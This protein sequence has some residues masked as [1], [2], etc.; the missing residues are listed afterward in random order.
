MLS[1]IIIIALILLFTFIGIK[2]G[3]ARTILNLAG[4]IVTAFVAN[5]LSEIASKWVYSTFIQ[6][7]V[8]T[9][10]S[11]MIQQNSSK[12]AL[13]NCFDAVPG[14]INSVLS[15]VMKLFGGNVNDISDGFSISQST[16]TSVAQAI[17][18]PLGEV[19]VAVLGIIFVVV[20]FIIIFILIKMLIRLA[21][22]FF[23]IPVIRQLNKVLGGIFGF[24]EGIVFVFLAINIFYAIMSYINPAILSNSLITGDI[25]KMFCN[26]L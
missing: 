25:F 5:W 1:N 13:E 15:S 2:R 12:Y 6:Q 22:K 17:E 11:D 16:S 3:I 10:L 4:L 7:S 23:E 8:I 20:L 19:V 9:N 21:L 26:F 24:A 18:K 14:W